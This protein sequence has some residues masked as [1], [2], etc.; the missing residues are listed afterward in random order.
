MKTAD[1]KTS[2]V[3]AALVHTHPVECACEKCVSM[4]HRTPCLCTPQDALRLVQSGLGDMLAATLWLAAGVE[5]AVEMV[6]IKAE[7]RGQLHDGAR[8]F[9]FNG[10]CALHS[11]GLKPTEGRLASCHHGQH[12]A[13]AVVMAVALSWQLPRNARLVAHLINLFDPPRNEEP[14]FLGNTIDNQ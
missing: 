2:D 9:L 14:I 12:E 8:P 6:Q 5:N 4:C 7:D 10:K 3:L 1:A 11:R 13:E